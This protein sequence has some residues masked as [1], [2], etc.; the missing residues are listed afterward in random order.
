MYLYVY[1]SFL[2]HQKYAPLIT[3]IERRVADLDIKGRVARLSVLKNTQELL[4]DAVKAGTS[5]IVAIGDDETFAKIINIVANLDVTLG[6]IPADGKS[7]IARVLG[8]PPRELACDVLAAR[9]IKKLD[10]GKIN[11]YFF[12]SSAEISNADVR[13]SC[14]GYSVQPTTKLN[15]VRI[16]NVDWDSDSVSNPTDGVLEA[17]ITPIEERWLTKRQLRSTVLPFTKIR[18]SAGDGGGVPILT[19]TQTILKT[20]AVVEI[21]PRKLRIIVGTRRRFL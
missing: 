16:C 18:I 20:P 9:I 7:K 21:A 1:D 4:R 5:T 2:S 6:L 8:I 10:L 11:N 12:L 19:D 15:S 3:A 13:I 17:I 14:N